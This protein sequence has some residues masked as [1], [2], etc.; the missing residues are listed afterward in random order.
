MVP[1]SPLSMRRHTLQLKRTGNLAIEAPMEALWWTPHKRQESA[2][3]T[4]TNESGIPQ[5]KAKTWGNLPPPATLKALGPSASDGAF[6][7][8]VYSHQSNCPPLERHHIVTAGA[9]MPYKLSPPARRPDPQPCTYL[10]LSPPS[11]LSLKQLP[12]LRPRFSSPKATL[13]FLCD[14][15]SLIASRLHR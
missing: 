1:Q 9:L 8:L 2:Q 6:L 5:T 15:P 11:P 12:P 7:S 3:V 4:G 14:T 13:T 10:V